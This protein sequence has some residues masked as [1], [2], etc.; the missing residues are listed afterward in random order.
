MTT[1]NSC[2]TLLILIAILAL[3][4]QA[5]SKT[6]SLQADRDNNLIE[7][8]QGSSSNG[9]SENIFVG[10]TNQSL[11]F[12]RRGLLH[13]PIETAIPAGSIVTSATLRLVKVSPSSTDTFVTLHRA[14]SNWGEGDAA[15]SGSGATSPPGDATWIHTFFD[16]EFWQT[17][18]GDFTATPSTTTP[19]ASTSGTVLFAPTTQTLNDIQTWIDSP[20]NNFGWLLKGKETI[21]RTSNRFFSRESPT[22]NSQPMLQIEFNGPDLLAVPRHLEFGEVNIENQTSTASITLSNIGAGT[23][24]LGE[25]SVSGTT[26]FQI[27]D[28]PASGTILT[29]GT[30]QKIAIAFNPQTAG[31]KQAAAIIKS[32]DSISSITQVQLTGNGFEL[33][34]GRLELSAAEIDFDIAIVGGIAILR[35]LEIRNSGD[36]NLNF[37]G[38]GIELIG[39]ADFSLL[40]PLTTTTLPSGEAIS[41]LLEFVPQAAG[42]T[43]AQLS[44]TT[45]DAN[46]PT[47]L[48]D[49]NGSGAEEIHLNLSNGI[50]GYNGTSDT[51]LYEFILDENRNTVSGESTGNGAG[52]YLFSGET[53]SYGKRRSLIAFDL[54]HISTATLIIQASLILNNNKA[55]DSN[56]PQTLNRITSA[57]GEG[58]TAIGG[59]EGGSQPPQADNGDATWKYRFYPDVRWDTEGGDFST[60][61]SAQTSS[62]N[63]GEQITFNSEQMLKDLRDWISGENPN[64]G[65]M[66]LGNEAGT[67]T[68][69]R[70]DSSDGNPQNHPLLQLTILHIPQTTASD[71]QQYILGNSAPIT[72]KEKNTL[73]SNQ[74][75]TIDISD[76]LN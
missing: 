18:G 51:V 4:L 75:N 64:Y 60:T 57:W 62:L 41:L 11:N 10:R 28:A 29:S 8:P 55:K 35:T 61:P 67:G 74:D 76:I 13:F 32:N 12:L 22:S 3:S 36:K 40:T 9:S 14:L 47:L 68:A 59:E 54:S 66:L 58:T 6:I 33:K 19:V 52:H 43:G 38:P 44:I 26:E 45:D 65:W 46:S 27:L 20:E 70:F 37:T 7:S 34:P 24:T 50:N 5:P 15:G 69:V 25:I 48:V 16:T 31:T 73:N 63:P 71:K 49:L 53:L 72:E 39:P 1:A 23:V 30:S 17:P 2:G 21:P 56:Q 42:L